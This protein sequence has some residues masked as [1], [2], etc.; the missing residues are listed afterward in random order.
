MP[1][2]KLRF[3]PA[4]RELLPRIFSDR[5]QHEE[6]GLSLD[7]FL[8]QQ[9]LAALKNHNAAG[10]WTLE[11]KDD[12]TEPTGTAKLNS[13]SLTLQ[14]PVPSTGLGEPALPPEPGEHRGRRH[15]HIPAARSALRQLPRRVVAY[16]RRR[17]R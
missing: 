1:V 9:A 10:V 12:A 6:A 14:K 17:A 4:G 11:I 2:A 13:W 16:D 15:H 5:F 8:P 3:L 7:L